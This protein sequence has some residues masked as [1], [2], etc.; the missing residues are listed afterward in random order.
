MH[1]KRVVLGWAL[2][3]G[4]GFLFQANAALAERVEVS[5]SQANLRE[6][7]TTQSGVVARLAPGTLLEVK[8][9][10]GAW[11]E[12][13]VVGTGKRGFISATLV[14]PVP[15]GAPAQAPPP[16]V[17]AHKPPAPPPS[18]AAPSRPSSSDREPA[19]PIRKASQ[20]KQP[21][22]HLFANAFLQPSLSISS[23]YTYTQYWEQASVSEKYA[24][25]KSFGFE[26]GAQ[27]RLMGPL[28]LHVAFSRASRKGTADVSAQFPHPFYFQQMRQVE[29]TI[30]ALKQDETAIHIDIAVFPRMGRLK[31]T[32]FVG[33]SL[34][35]SNIDL[36]AKPTITESYPYDTVVA[37]FAS[38]K[39]KATPMGFNGGVSLDFLFTKSLGIGAQFRY[40]TAKAKF[41]QADKGTIEATLGGAQASLGLRAI[42]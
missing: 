41:E 26:I 25:D 3:V 23:S 15:E 29:G 24:Y 42:F 17:Q 6:R 27:A 10:V 38:E 37:D 2:C 31:A 40:S 11:Y 19:E 33:V 18:A 22:Y 28:G 5:R 21:R 32:A 39:L 35:T 12:V 7:P 36:L 34:F 9:T 1:R 20:E 14:T 16:R 8:A 4:L 30:E 13:T